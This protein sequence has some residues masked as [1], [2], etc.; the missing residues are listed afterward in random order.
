VSQGEESHSPGLLF[1]SLDRSPT[2]KLGQMTLES[3]VRGN[4][5]G[6]TGPVRHTAHSSVAAAWATQPV[7]AS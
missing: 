4:N 1:N 7:P 2:I 3:K 6:P 5:P